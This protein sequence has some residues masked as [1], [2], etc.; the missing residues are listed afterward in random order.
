M[1]INPIF[2]HD[3][4]QYS[5]APPLLLEIITFFQKDIIGMERY[6]TTS[7]G[8]PQI[9]ERE[10]DL[11]GR[12]KSSFFLVHWIHI[13][14]SLGHPWEPSHVQV[15]PFGRQKCLLKDY[16]RVFHIQVFQLVL[17]QCTLTWFFEKKKCWN[18]FIGLSQLLICQLG[19]KLNR[20]KAF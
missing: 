8:P 5:S 7:I 20:H 15:F 4:F 10:G 1:K 16:P 19:K 2:P 17:V 11:V 6:K 12:R 14:P 13:E 18:F 3:M 9:L